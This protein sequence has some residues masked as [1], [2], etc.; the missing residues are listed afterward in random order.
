MRL[1]LINPNTTSSMTAAMAKAGASV[2]AQG[3]ELLDA[4]AQYGPESIE[5]Y[6]DE[7]F[8]VP[9]ILDIVAAW[10]SAVDGV[11]IGCFDDTGVDAARTL[12]DVPVIGICQAAMQAAATLAG[13]FSVVTTLGRAVPALEHLALR[14]GYER[15]CRRVR[16][17]EVPVLELENDRGDASRRIRAQIQAA[18][19]EE[20]AEAIVLGCAGMANFAKV[21][22]Q[23]FEVPVIEGVTVALK[24][25]ESLA[26]LGLKTSSRGGYAPPRT[27]RFQGQAL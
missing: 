8:S 26:C 11:V 25:V 19:D 23:E 12:T 7:A 16:S 6:Y 10:Q 24:W 2:L 9:P 27:K 17:C 13:S 4:T 15:V 1:L 14:Y 3:T 20:G 18:L 21:L 5:G 22:S